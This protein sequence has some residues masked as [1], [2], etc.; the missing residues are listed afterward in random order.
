MTFAGSLRVKLVFYRD[1]LERFIPTKVGCKLTGKNQ[2]LLW[3]VYYLRYDCWYHHNP[4]KL[5]HFLDN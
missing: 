2:V 4:N 1:L 5:E 3:P